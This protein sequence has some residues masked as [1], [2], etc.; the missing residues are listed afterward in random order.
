MNRA[1]LLYSVL[2]DGEPHSRRDIQRRVGYFLTNNA[3]SELRKRGLNVVH[4]RPGRVDTYQLVR[5]LS[6]NEGTGSVA[7]SSLSETGDDIEG[8]ASCLLS[9]GGSPG[10]AQLSLDERNAA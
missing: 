3:A 7:V 4:S 1:D 5:P 8:P 9:P 10:L 2:K 6:L